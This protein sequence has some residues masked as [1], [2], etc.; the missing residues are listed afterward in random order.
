MQTPKEDT[1]RLYTRPVRYQWSLPN[2]TVCHSSSV[3]LSRTK[4]GLRQAM[5]RFW[6]RNTHVSP[7][8]A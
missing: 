5:R 2:G 8:E 7:E 3:V 6:T 1:I 4:A